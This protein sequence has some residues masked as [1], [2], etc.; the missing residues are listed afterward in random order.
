MSRKVDREGVPAEDLALPRTGYRS[1]QCALLIGE[2]LTRCTKSKGA[3]TDR[4][5][6]RGLRGL[7]TLRDQ[8]Q[9]LLTVLCIARRIAPAVI[10]WLSG[11]TAMATL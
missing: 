2:G 9:G 5:A 3:I 10:S 7:F 8:V 11:A 6:D 1:D 4:L